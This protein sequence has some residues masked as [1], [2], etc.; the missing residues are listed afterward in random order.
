VIDELTA[1]MSDTPE[2]L[3]SV[4]QSGIAD[5]F[6]SVLAGQLIALILVAGTDICGT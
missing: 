5:I 4:S 2:R 3:L 1:A 6:A